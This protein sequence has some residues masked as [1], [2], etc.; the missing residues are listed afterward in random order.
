[1]RIEGIGI[2]RDLSGI[3]VVKIPGADYVDAGKQTSWLNL[4]KTIRMDEQTGVLIP[5]DRDESGN[6]LYE[7][8]LQSTA[9]QH[10]IDTDKV[11]ARYERWILRVLLS[12][13]MALGDQGGGSF[14]LGVSKSELFVQFVQ[15]ILDIIADTVT[16]QAIRP[17][18][19]VNGIADDHAPKM[20]FEQISK[21][22]L[23]KFAAAFQLLVAAGS[24]DAN[25]PQVRDVV[26]KEIGLPVPEGGFE[27]PEPQSTEARDNALIDAALARQTQTAQL[28]PGQERQPVGEGGQAFTEPV[29]HNLRERAR[30]IWR[31]AL[32]D[33]DDL[34]SLLDAKVVNG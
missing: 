16:N 29:S 7:F 12:D 6:P 26:Y 24:V 32:G 31:E 11:I 10:Q 18:C 34:A 22:D 4:I 5:S 9:G 15:G 3:P 21:S 28:P 27:A 20:T 13:W 8:T 19:E 25:D 33:D 14:A 1:M 23:T 2:E 30:A 17:L